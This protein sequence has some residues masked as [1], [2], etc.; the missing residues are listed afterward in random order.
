MDGSVSSTSK[1]VLENHEA[2]LEHMKQHYLESLSSQGP[3]PFSMIRPPFLD[4]KQGPDGT[5]QLRHNKGKPKLS[6]IFANQAAFAACLDVN[7]FGEPHLY[8]VTQYLNGAHR[9]VLAEVALR[10]LYMLQT[11]LTGVEPTTTKFRE[12]LKVCPEALAEICGVYEF[13]EGKYE[14]GNYRKGAPITEYL[15]SAL[16]HE[17]SSE[18]RDA[19]SGK[20]H[21]AHA[22][23]NYWQVL[24]QPAERD[25]RLPRVEL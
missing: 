23:W 7:S 19:E 10:T 14:R 2:W 15:D 8:Y 6:F 9:K 20:H 4:K 22:F 21:L 5:Q 12:L 17:L 24:N 1:Q 16:R 18:E 25:D 13:G 11:E 3:D